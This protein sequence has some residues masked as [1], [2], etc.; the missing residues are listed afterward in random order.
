MITNES[1]AAAEAGAEAEA[2]ENYFVS[3]TDMMVGVL[4]PKANPHTDDAA[5]ALQNTMVAA[6]RGLPGE[7]RA[8]AR[9]P[10]LY[11]VAHN[12]SV[13][14]LRQRRPQVELSE[15]LEVEGHAGEATTR[16]RLAQLVED[17]GDLPV[18]QRGALVLREL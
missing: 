18:R 1:N 6:M 12:E 3:M 17:L 9:K 2:G 11:R 16:E 10:W 15:A 5:D 13:S 7:R 14:L 8:L 4:L